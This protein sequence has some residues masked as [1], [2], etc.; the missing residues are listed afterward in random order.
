M[1][2]EAI[3]DHFFF[4]LSIFFCRPLGSL[5]SMEILVHKIDSYHYLLVYCYFQPLENTSPEFI[6]FTLN[7]LNWSLSLFLSF[8]KSVVWYLSGLA[9]DGTSHPTSNWSHLLKKSLMLYFIFCAVL[10]T[11]NLR[12]FKIYSNMILFH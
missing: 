1:R 7:W 9:L 12:V 4:F 3:F 2:F 6:T 5:S 11:L 8:Q 10:F